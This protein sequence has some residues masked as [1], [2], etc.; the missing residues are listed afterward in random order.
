MI[1]TLTNNSEILTALLL[2]IVF[3]SGYYLSVRLEKTKK[4]LKKTRLQYLSEKSAAAVLRKNNIVVQEELI[5][6]AKYG[7]NYHR[8]TRY[9]LL[10]FEKNCLDNFLQTL[11]NKKLR[12]WG[13][14]CTK[15][16]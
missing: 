6:A 5:A 11:E 1:P 4:E 2:F 14:G 8:T 3:T 15:T 10:S 9:T 13:I 7:Y 12:K 16:N